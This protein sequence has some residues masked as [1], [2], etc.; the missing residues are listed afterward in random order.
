MDKYSFRKI[1]T[2]KKAPAIQPGHDFRR[3]GFGIYGNS[4]A[5]VLLILI[6]VHYSSYYHQNK[7]NN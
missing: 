5:N 3:R 6:P 2:S 7:S 4:D 1:F